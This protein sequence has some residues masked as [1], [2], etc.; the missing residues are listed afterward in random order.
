M[1]LSDYNR[2]KLIAR[3]QRFEAI[4]WIAF[5]FS[6]LSVAILVIYLSGPRAGVS[7]PF[8]VID[9]ALGALFV[10]EFTSRTGFRTRPI[11]YVLSHLFDFVAIVPVLALVNRGYW[12]EAVWV[13]VILA[14]RASR[15]IDRVL[16]DGF[17][18][19]NF[20]ALAEGFEEEITDRVLQRIL[21]RIQ[22]NLERSN[23]GTEIGEAL[24]R[25]KEKILARIDA[26]YTF[27]RGIGRIAHAI[28]FDTLVKQTEAKTLD[29]IVSVLKS[30]EVNDTIRASITS[31]FTAMHNEM[32]TKTWREN[33]GLKEDKEINST[34]ENTPKDSE[35]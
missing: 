2:E 18:Q 9:V 15:V 8:F 14:A 11:R 21:V 30:P 29:S 10:L 3:K 26:E 22:K 23:F 4:R 25:N 32:E 7:L 19:R 12:G 27:D 1:K 24:E 34:V 17:I 35:Y 20:L 5:G 28:G 13:W 31:V 6:L 33:L 16:G